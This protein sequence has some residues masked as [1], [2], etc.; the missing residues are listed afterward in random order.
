MKK[1]LV[2]LPLG[3]CLAG[4]PMDGYLGQP[5]A[6]TAAAPSTP[7]N[8][9]TFLSRLE[10]ARGTA[11]TT[12]EKTAVGGAVQQTR[13]LLDGG[14]QRFIG[15][16]SQVSGL[17]PATLGI[18]FPPATQPV[19]Q[20]DVVAKLESKAGRKLGGIESQAAKAAASLRNNSLAS[21][22]TNL[23]GRV[24]KE[25]GMDAAFVEGLLPLLGF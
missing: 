15:A 21:L 22:K 17:D 4:C 16:V 7:M 5:S 10:S 19:S 24:A 25:V 6:G 13:S 12:A 2:I 20:T 1:L 8:L 18:L 9:T 3:L 14:Q 11:L 23:A